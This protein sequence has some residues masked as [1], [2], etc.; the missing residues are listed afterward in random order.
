M[1]SADPVTD[2]RRLHPLTPVLRGWKALAG[3]LAISFQ[4]L[5]A[6]MEVRWLFLVVAVAL[7]VVAGYGWLSWRA[8]SYRITGEG[9]F[10]LESG[11]L[12]R[13][14]RRV[15]LDR[16]QAVDVVRPLVARALGLAELRLEVAGGASSGAPLAYLAEPAALALRAE[17]LARAA[18]VE[19]QEEGTSPSAAPE[20]VL[21]HVPLGRLVEGVLRSPGT[22]VAALF[23]VGS[24]LAAFLTRRWEPLLFLGPAAFT[25]GP[26]MFSLVANSFDFTLAQSSDGVRLRRGLLETRAQ[27]VPP[28]RVQALRIV[29]P[30]LWRRRGWCRVE[31]NIAGYVGEDTAQTAVLLPV[32]THEEVG[33]VLRL[34]FPDLDIGTVRLAGVPDRARWL[35]P[36]QRRFLAVG[37]DDSVSVVRRG[38]LTRRTDVVPHGKVQSVRLAQGLLQRRMGLA[39]VAIDTTPGPVRALAPHRDAHE[40]RQLVEALVERGRSARAPSVLHAGEPAPH[41]AETA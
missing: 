33:L 40:A 17:L 24:A 4:Q 21:L 11:V 30:W 1:T 6:G 2:F 35:D 8:T 41:P 16:L 37:L 25:A 32:G 27:T 10:V 18:G 12:H 34:V 23:V 36:W 9:D 7:P 26:A 3:V 13:R 39:A 5:Y 31:V 14:S 19:V 29:E 38:R 15:R 28:G 22:V 20:Q